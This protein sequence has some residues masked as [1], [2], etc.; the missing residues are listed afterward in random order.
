M[1]HSSSLFSTLVPRG[2]RLLPVVAKKVLPALATSAIGGLGGL[3][4]N[5]IPNEEREKQV[6]L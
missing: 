6:V 1:Q 4:M 3:V 2:T 5:K